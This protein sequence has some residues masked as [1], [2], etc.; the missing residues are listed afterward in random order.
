MW[1]SPFEPLSTEAESQKPE[2]IQE[3][4]RTHALFDQAAPLSN[5]QILLQEGALHQTLLAFNGRFK[6]CD[7]C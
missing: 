4:A 6:G 7:A 2:A 3:A 5:A 1:V